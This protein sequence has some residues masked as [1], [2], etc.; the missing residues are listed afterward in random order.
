MRGALHATEIPFVLDTVRAKYQSTLSPEDQ[1][2]AET[3][4]AY[5][6]AFARSG[7]PNGSALP[8]WPAYTA[9]TDLIMDFTAAGPVAGPDPRRIRL[10][11]VEALASAPPVP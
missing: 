8:R 11:L 4:S 1:A 7:D 10:D 9:E 2:M 5:W 6:A 3:M